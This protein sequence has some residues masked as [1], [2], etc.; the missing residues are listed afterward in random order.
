MLQAIEK[1]GF[2]VKIANGTPRGSYN[3]KFG[4]FPDGFDRYAV[5]NCVNCQQPLHLFLQIDMSDPQFGPAL[6]SNPNIHILNCLNCD[7]YWRPLYYRIDPKAAAIKILEQTEGDHFGEFPPVL[8]EEEIAFESLHRP[9]SPEQERKHQFGGQPFWLQGAER[10]ACRRCD[11]PMQFIAQ[12]DSDETLGIMFGDMGLLY[13]FLC[14][15]CGVF[16]T[17]TQCF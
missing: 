7:S 4:G 8:P 2:V 15:K 1:T 11:G 3:H 12:V 14:Q 17:F 6:A 9:W 10:P 5:P 13:A 16:A